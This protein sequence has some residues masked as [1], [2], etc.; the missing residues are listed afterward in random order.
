ME[1][2]R[3][4]QL[5]AVLITLLVLTFVTVALRCWVRIKIVK[6][7][8]IDDW[9][10]LATLLSFTVYCGIVFWGTSRGYGRHMYYLSADEKRDSAKSFYF[11][12]IFN[13]MCALLIRLTVG[14]FLL[15]VAVKK[16][17]RWT[18]YIILATNSLA[19]VAFFFVVIFQCKPVDYYWTRFYPGYTGECLVPSF[20]GSPFM[21]LSILAISTDL[22]LGIIPILIVKDLNMARREKVHVAAILCIGIIICLAGIIRI[23]YSIEFVHDDDF[24]YREMDIAIWSSVEPGLGIIAV[25]CASLRPLIRTIRNRVTSKKST[26]NLNSYKKASEP[27][28]SVRPPPPPKS[29]SHSDAKYGIDFDFG[30]DDHELRGLQAGTGTISTVEA[31]IQKPSRSRLQKKLTKYYGHPGTSS[32]G[33][34]PPESSNGMGYGGF[35]SSASRSGNGRER[36]DGSRIGGR[37]S[38]D[39]NGEDWEIT[40]TTELSMNSEMQLSRPPQLPVCT[41][42]EDED[43]EEARRWRRRNGGGGAGYAV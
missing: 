25:S 14:A 10:T 28:R 33:N 38:P 13:I 22:G 27:K 31:G 21:A 6:A 34:S 11:A 37:G 9:L 17:H 24:L 43:E 29:Y 3:G 40:K 39:S 16:G 18:I 7:F 12:E 26:S 41:F 1:G 23:P 4:Y 15:R 35:Y 30:F 36:G 2:D 5:D 42:D 19:C 8:A 32:G 20:N